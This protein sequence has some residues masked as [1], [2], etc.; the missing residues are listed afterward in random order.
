ML[1]LE[2]ILAV[3][4]D[5]TFLDFKCPETGY[6]LW[7][8]I[9]QDFIK[10]I[11][12]DLLYKSAPRISLN[13]DVNYS[14]ALPSLVK[15]NFHNLWFGNS[16]RGDV[17]LMASGAGLFVRD[18]KWFNRLSDYFALA[19]SQQ[20]MVLEDFFNWNWPQPRENKKV[21]YHAP[22]QTYFAL[23]G[24]L[25]IKQSHVR[26]GKNIVSHFK[27]RAKD[28]LDW[29]L[30]TSATLNFEHRMARKIAEL[31]IRKK[32]YENLLKQKGTKL[33]I[34]EEGC[35]GHSS[36][37]NRTAREMGVVVAE[38]QHGTINVGHDAY[39]VAPKLLSGSE[40][41]Y[42]LPQHFLSYGEWWHQYLALPVNKIAIGNP[43][44]ETQISRLAIRNVKM[45]ILVLGEGIETEMSVDLA[46]FLSENLTG[47]R[48]VF[49][50]HPLERANLIN[51]LTRKKIGKVVVDQNLDIYNAF[52]NAHVV[53]G[54][55]ST[56]LY[57][58]LGLA[59][60]V[61][62]WDTP[63]SRFFYRTHPFASFIDANDLLEKIKDGN[64]GL[65]DIQSVHSVWADDWEGNYKN[66]LKQYTERANLESVK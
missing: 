4:D 59:D 41:K 63:K 62:I 24:R 56:G 25:S 47:W 12:S 34:K 44:R 16:V 30:N 39:N 65:L 26:Q 20:T 31:P 29:D 46:I 1:N 64:T 37:L 32:M 8:L 13:L 28:I 42:T 23:M 35:Y 60:R 19:N 66:F 15:A 36:I 53:V 11:I 7:P 52:C 54:E 10:L 57:E 51:L 21:I 17:L 45:D 48:V 38:Y 18:G 55:V 6:L 14:I 9:R 49:R 3:E 61:L 58:A 22:M 27:S 40:Y 5:S 2:G 33:V 43:H 50:P